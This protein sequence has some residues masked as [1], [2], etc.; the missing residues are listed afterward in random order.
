MGTSR[1]IGEIETYGGGKK[2]A[3]NGQRIARVFMRYLETV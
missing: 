2:G 3:K 1:Y